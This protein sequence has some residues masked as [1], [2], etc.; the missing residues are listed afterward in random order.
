MRSKLFR[1]RVLGFL[2]GGM[3]GMLAAASLPEVPEAAL[4][5]LG[6]TPGTPQNG[7]FVFVDGR[8]LPPPYTVTRHGNGIFINRIQVEQPVP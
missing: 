1:V 7:G 8:Y 6:S 5:A 3:A 4:E 2:V